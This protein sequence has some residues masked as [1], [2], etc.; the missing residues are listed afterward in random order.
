MGAE[1][2]NGG[3]GGLQLDWKRVHGWCWKGFLDGVGKG[4]WMVLERRFMGGV[5]EEVQHSHLDTGTLG[6]QYRQILTV[7]LVPTCITMFTACSSL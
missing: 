3:E 5:G 1:V 6:T 4:S 2:E 7:A